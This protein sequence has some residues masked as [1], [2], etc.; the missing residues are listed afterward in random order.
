MG[1]YLPSAIVLGTSITIGGFDIPDP[2]SG[3]L[4][5]IPAFGIGALGWSVQ[6]PLVSLLAFSLHRPKGKSRQS[7]LAIVHL[8]YGALIPTLAMVNFPQSILL[9]TITIAYLV[10][11]RPLRL[12]LLGLHPALIPGLKEEWGLGNVVWPGVFAVWVPLWVVAVV[13]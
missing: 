10:P 11:Y 4:Y 6:T 5:L 2:L 12:G 8:L 1:H 13:I 3:V 9:A 7:L